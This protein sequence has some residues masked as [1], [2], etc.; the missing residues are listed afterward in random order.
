MQKKKKKHEIHIQI[1]TWYIAINNSLNR[2]KQK[3]CQAQSKKKKGRRNYQHTE[4]KKKKKRQKREGKHAP[5]TE[6]SDPQLYS[7]PR[8]TLCEEPLARFRLPFLRRR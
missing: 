4:R 8:L 3:D 6:N 5:S 2:R 7:H 1:N